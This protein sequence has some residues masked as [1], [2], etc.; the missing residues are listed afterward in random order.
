MKRK[1][2]AVF[3]AA[4]AVTVGAGTAP[5]MT[6]AA[7]TTA[8]EADAA[9]TEDGKSV[10]KDVSVIH[11]KDRYVVETYDGEAHGLQAEVYNSRGEKVAEPTLY[12]VGVDGKY[13]DTEKPVDAGTYQVTASYLGD[14][15]HLPAV[16]VYAML[17]IEKAPEAVVKIDD[18]TTELGSTDPIE[19][20]YQTT[21]VAARDIDTI[22]ASIACEGAD[23]AVG[24][25]PINGVADETTASNYEKVTVIPGTHTI[26]EKEEPIDPVDPVD[27]VDPT[28]PEDPTDPTDPSNPE[29]PENP[30][31]TAGNETTGA[32]QKPE[33]VK[34]GDNAPVAALS[35]AMAVALGAAAVVISKKRKF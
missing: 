17:V 1:W 32:E 4:V 14:E 3:A 7:D 21:N 35:G 9:V 16:D 29:E 5:L 27:P 13:F 18:I 6:K 11:F 2:L 12:Y 22:L 20:T 19:Y 15:D 26:I 10:V 24:Q 23:D 33:T 8:T 31:D 28:D 30:T 34:T 25:H